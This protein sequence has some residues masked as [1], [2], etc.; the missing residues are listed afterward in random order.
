MS[1]QGEKQHRRCKARAKSSA[2][3]DKHVFLKP[4]TK[5]NKGRRNLGARSHPAKL[6]ACE[7]GLK[8]SLRVEG[9]HQQEQAD[10][11]GSSRT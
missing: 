10:A 3:G 7:I 11:P 1:S 5:W 6:P 2:P 4:D 9:N 8:K